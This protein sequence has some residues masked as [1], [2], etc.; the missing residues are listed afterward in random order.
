MHL[1]ELTR[2][3]LPDLARGAARLGAGGGGDP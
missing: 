1:T 3:D 2:D